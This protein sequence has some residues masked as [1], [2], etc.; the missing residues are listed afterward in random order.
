MFWIRRVSF[1]PST[2]KNGRSTTFSS[3][4]WGGATKPSA[5]AKPDCHRSPAF[6]MESWVWVSEAALVYQVCWLAPV[7]ERST[8]YTSSRAFLWAASSQASRSAEEPVV[9]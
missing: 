2:R 4:Y 8:L 5:E 1:P 3:A 9:V 7:R 6:Q